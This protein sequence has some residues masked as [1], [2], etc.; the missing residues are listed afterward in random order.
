LLGVAPRRGAVFTDA[1][2]EARTVTIQLSVDRF[3]GKIAVLATEDGRQIEFPR[4]ML[5]G[6]VKAGELL[7]LSLERDVEGTRKLQAET[8]K[9]QADLRN[10]D[11]GG[12][13]KL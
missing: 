1:H 2:R 11:P 7:T 8:R 4:D 12:D 10:R 6:A 13:I 9:V 3:E 5:P